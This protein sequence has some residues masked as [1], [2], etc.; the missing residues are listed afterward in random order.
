MNNDKFFNVIQKN[1]KKILPGKIFLKEITISKKKIFFS[2]KLS[3][4]TLK[5]LLK[6]F[7]LFCIF[8]FLQLLALPLTLKVIKA[9]KRYNHM[10]NE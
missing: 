3:V 4:V 8:Y 5:K 1:I 2:E 7:C 9:G 6:T 10:N